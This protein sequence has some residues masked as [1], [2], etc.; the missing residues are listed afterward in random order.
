MDGMEMGWKWNGTHWEEGPAVKV[1]RAQSAFSL[2]KKPINKQTMEK[3]SI[4]K[5]NKKKEYIN[6][7]GESGWQK[8]WKKLERNNEWNEKK[9]DLRNEFRGGDEALING[10]D[11]WYV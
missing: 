6:L 11:S 5:V 9:S 2:K 3:K 8:L 1:I 10:Q 4:W 7:L